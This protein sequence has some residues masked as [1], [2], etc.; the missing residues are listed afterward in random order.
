M[1]RILVSDEHGVYRTGLRR[2]LE[3]EIPNAE[4]VEASSLS[5]SFSR[6][7]SD[8]FFDLVLMNL[9]LSDVRSLEALKSACESS[10]A[11]RFAILS[12]SDSH[13]E[14]LAS[15]AGGFHGFISKHQA[16][17]E[18][19]GAIK[20]LL[21]GRVYVPRSL[22]EAIDQD[23]GTDREGGEA[24]PMIA[25][26]ADLL[27]LTPRQREV[28]SLLARGMS[29][30]EIAR[31]LQ[32]ADATTKINMAALLRALGVRNRTEAAF[33]AASLIQPPSG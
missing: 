7:R 28:L 27:K 32:I 22:A 12:D 3:R 18:V 20:D 9:N 16:D 4:V 15:L 19:I 11:S 21:S 30:K 6:I 26:E 5:E 17:D 10:P 33:K 1:P 2:I 13:E 24:L 8:E 31:A 14:I 25:T 23:P 29:N